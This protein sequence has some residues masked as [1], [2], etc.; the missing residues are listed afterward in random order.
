MNTEIIEFGY[1]LLPLISQKKVSFL[2]KEIKKLRDI[3]PQLPIINI[4]DSFE[5]NPFQIR[6]KKEQI[7]DIAFDMSKESIAVETIISIIKDYY[8]Y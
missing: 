8:I 2:L 6:I 5:I 4:I 7:F 1:G 3:Y